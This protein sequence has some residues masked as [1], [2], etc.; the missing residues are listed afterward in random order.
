[1][2]QL[3]GLDASF[4]YL[5]TPNFH[6]HVAGLG[7]FDPSTAPGGKV[8]FLDFRE[9]VAR[10][11]HKVPLFRRRVMRV[12]LDLDH[13]YWVDDPHFDLDYHLHHVSLPAP[14]GIDGLWDFFARVLS[15]PMDQRR[16]LWEMYFIEGLGKIEG[17]PRGSF[18]TITKMHH[19]AVDGVSGE[20]VLTL[21]MDL[22][23][24]P[25]RRD[26]E[27]EPWAP[28]P[29][30]SELEL[31]G[32]ALGHS[33]TGPKHAIELLPKVLKSAKGVIEKEIDK[34]LHRA[35][36]PEGPARV[37][38]TPFNGSVTGRRVYDALSISLDDVRAIKRTIEGATV[39]DVI[40]AVCSGGIRRYLEEKD[41]L[42]E[43]PMCTMAPVSVRTAD[44]KGALGNRVS[45]LRCSLGTHLKDP[46]ERFRHIHGSTT[47][48]KEVFNAVDRSL[49]TE[50]TAFIPSIPLELAARLATRTHAAD[51][52]GNPL[53]NVV[54]TNVP[55][56]PFPVYCCGAKLLSQYGS[57]PIVDG[58]GLIIVVLSYCGEITLGLTSCAKM[59]P[60]LGRVAEC[61]REAMAELKEAA[62]GPAAKATPKAPAKRKKAAAPKAPAKRKAPKKD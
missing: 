14:G 4:L 35:D 7:I 28:A 15:R 43:E 12:P 16:P 26:P 54:I 17:Y 33:V 50:A 2:Q 44:E 55:G 30:P 57:G 34:R 62:L 60:D 20:E 59:T 27:P 9:V 25:E 32:R 24:N 53:F 51:K 1:M 31:L 23:A 52:Y 46:L 48:A 5:E 10:R 61:L 56:P 6:M 37:P 8:R 45:V 47:H 29:L 36:A 42:P 41:A 21:V 19:A 22:E 11:I 49:M 58:A 3:G 18:A 40:L 38:H 39:N 13:P